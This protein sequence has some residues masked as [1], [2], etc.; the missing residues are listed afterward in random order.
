MPTRKTAPCV[1]VLTIVCLGVAIQAIGADQQETEVTALIKALASPNPAPKLI[2]GRDGERW[3]ELPQGYDLGAQKRV[4]EAWDKLDELGFAAF[5]Q[6]V[7]HF[8]DERYCTTEDYDVGWW[9][10]CFL[11]R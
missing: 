7:Q 1:C 9:R 2:K 5:P 8:E 6:L 3:Y 4:H 10:N 11:R